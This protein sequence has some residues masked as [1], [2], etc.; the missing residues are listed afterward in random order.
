MPTDLTDEQID[1]H[2]EQHPED[3]TPLV[4]RLRAQN[5]DLARTAKRVPD[6]EAKLAEKDF[7]DVLKT[8]GLDSLNQRQQA[9][10]RREVGDDVSEDSLWETASDLFGVTRPDAEK[11]VPDEEQQALD[12]QAATATGAEAPVS[13][14]VIKPEE[15]AE[16]P[17]D[18]RMAFLKKH[19]DEHERLLRG[20]TVLGVVF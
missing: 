9:T 10:L 3:D 15:A 16:W 12:R 5:K 11:V 2:L 7:G 1:A 17:M 13:T 18:K 4:Q 8:A 14:G 19:P 20:E 6:L